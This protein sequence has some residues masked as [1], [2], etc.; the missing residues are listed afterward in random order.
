MDT[1]KLY[2]AAIQLSTNPETLF[3]GAF[4]HLHSSVTTATTLFHYGILQ[5]YR[6]IVTRSF[7]HIRSVGQNMAN[8]QLDLQFAITVP[9]L[10]VL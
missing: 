9:P 6:K 8:D 10:W 4:I 2:S 5:A 1:S 3:S 7:P